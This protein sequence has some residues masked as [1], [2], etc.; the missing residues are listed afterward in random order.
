MY[1]TN[2]NIKLSNLVKVAVTERTQSSVDML[3][4]IN[5]ILSDID[6]TEQRSSDRTAFHDQDVT[7]LCHSFAIISGFRQAILDLMHSIN[8]AKPCTIDEAA[9]KKMLDGNGPFS[10]NKMLTVFLGCI[11]PRSFTGLQTNQSAIPETV[12]NRLV[13]R[14]AFEVEGWKR[15][16]T[17][18]FLKLGL[19]EGVKY[20]FLNT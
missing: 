9:V 18:M 20:F 6:S 17:N 12:V 19:Q 8:A 13:F 2:L 16:V 3:A 5:Q 11:N 7:A 14:T 1:Q 15:I 4:E 10:F